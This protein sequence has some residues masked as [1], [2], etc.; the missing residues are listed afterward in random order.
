M[1]WCMVELTV[2]CPAC[3]SP[4]HIRGPGR[5]VPCGG[6]M[7][8]FEFPPAVWKDTLQEAVGESRRQ[9]PGEGSQS[10]IFGH[11]NMSL[12]YG[13]LA[14]YCRNCKR[15]FHIEED[16]TGD[17]L[18]CAGCGGVMPFHPPPGWFEEVIPGAKILAGARKEG[19]EESCRVSVPGSRGTS[20]PRCPG[21]AAPLPADGSER[22]VKCLYCGTGVFLPDELQPSLRPA[23][24]KQR[25]FIGF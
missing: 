19:E 1:R 3:D 7:T 5:Q 16:R 24:T 6:C 22:L 21:C 25:W 11:F 14:P 2:K 12:L 23:S 17:A 4:V 9:K 18:V 20:V 8:V 10:T 15:D 13:N